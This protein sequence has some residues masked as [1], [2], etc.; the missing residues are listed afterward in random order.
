MNI[1]VDDVTTHINKIPVA[2][3]ISLEVHEG[4][5]IGI[6]G[7]NGSGKSTILK[8]MYRALPYQSGIIYIDNKDFASLSAKESAKQMAV[9]SQ[10]G[11]ASF[12]FTVEE[13][14]FMGR[15]PH[16]KWF[17][18]DSTD[19]KEIVKNALEQVGLFDKK[20]R[21]FST[22]S[23]G[24]KQ[25]VL[26]ARAISQQANILILDEPTNHLD[27]HHQLQVMDLA[28]SLNLTV[29]AA[30]H[31]LNIAAT[32]C[33]RIYVVH[34]G[35]IVRSGTAM[36]VLT[37]EMLRAIFNVNADVTMHPKTGNVHLTYLSATR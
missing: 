16:K 33:D 19:D 37:E 30:L 5:F 24:E 7:P 29:I 4:E 23:G 8:S 6:I 17:D 15:A 35:V 11:S 36:D 1:L 21:G 14:V 34:D 26:I 28:K 10:E 12:D 27:I 9:V 22:L 32:Y 2:R 18:A 31:D 13:M 25:R 20:T 3:N